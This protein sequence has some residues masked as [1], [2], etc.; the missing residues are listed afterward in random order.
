[1]FNNQQKHSNLEFSHCQLLIKY[2]S[3]SHFRRQINA[4]FIEYDSLPLLRT[5]LFVQ[6]RK[7]KYHI[8]YVVLNRSRMIPLSE[9]VS[10][11]LMAHKHN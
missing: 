8:T 3:T 2:I 10:S 7:L 4:S 6:H 5:V 1:V 11:F 9:S